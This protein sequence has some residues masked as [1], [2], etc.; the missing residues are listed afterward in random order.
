[1][2]LGL[3]REG[4]GMDDGYGAGGSVVEGSR[5]DIRDEK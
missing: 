3:A 4:C 1:M 2:E 5:R